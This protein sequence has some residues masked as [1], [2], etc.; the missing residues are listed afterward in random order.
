MTAS[1]TWISTRD[2]VRRHADAHGDR[3]AAIA[4]DTRVTYDRLA[5]RTGALAAALRRA[6]VGPGVQVAVMLS[7][8]VSSIAWYYA[9]LEAGGIIV[10]LS[11]NLAGAEARDLIDSSGAWF[12][13]ASHAASLPSDLDIPMERCSAPESEGCLW[14]VSRDLPRIDTVPWT[15]P[16]YMTRRTSS[17]ST[18]R[19]KHVFKTEANLAF[20]LENFRESFGLG[21]R[22]VFLGAL[23]LFS[24]MG[25]YGFTL[26]MHLGAC[27]TILPRFLPGAVLE[28]ARRDRATVFFASPAMIDTLSTCVLQEGDEAAFRSLRFCAAGGAHLRRD[29]S[30]AFRNRFGVPVHNQYGSSESHTIAVDTEEPFVEGRAGRPLRGVEVRI[31]DDDDL[32]LPAGAIGRIVAR[33]PAAST[34]YIGD[35]ESTAKVFRDGWVFPGDRVYLDSEGRLHVLGRDDVINI[36]GMKVD[37]LEVARTIR[38]ALPVR[39]VVVL[40]ADRA[41]LPTLRAIV[42]ADPAQVT[43]K[44]VVDACRVRLSSYKVPTQIDVRDR[45]ERND[46][47]KILMS[48]LGKD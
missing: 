4:G 32:P 23:P 6:G 29:V 28:T 44:M 46:A 36:D 18:G 26:A 2:V 21:E 39:D 20:D 41:G 13:A 27:V 5:E 14:R 16:G 34:S 35:P 42:E 7:N 47:G 19:P 37:P 3:I 40:A 48:S 10:Q 30:E 12:V 24:P 11:P 17:G 43:A 22:D 45:L 25:S 9:V 31:L 1:G 33:N 38:D 8:A 15:G